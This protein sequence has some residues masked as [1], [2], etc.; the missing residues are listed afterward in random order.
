MGGRGS[1]SGMGREQGFSFTTNQG[2]TTVVQ[3]TATGIVIVNG[4]RKTGMDYDKLYEAA[5]NQDG[6]KEY[7]SKQIAGTRRKRAKDF[8]SHDYELLDNTRGKR[9]TVYRYRKGR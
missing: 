2:K 8:N 7:S 6:F 9:K 3:K 5:K 1:S 4:Q